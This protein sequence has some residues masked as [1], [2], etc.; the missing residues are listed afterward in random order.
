[1]S[2]A[3]RRKTFASRTWSLCV[4]LCEQVSPQ[5][6]GG[7]LWDSRWPKGQLSPALLCSRSPAVAVTHP[8]LGC[9]CSLPALEVETWVGTLLHSFVGTRG[10]ASVYLLY[11]VLLCWLSIFKIKKNNKRKYLSQLIITAPS[12]SFADRR[13]VWTRSCS[14]QTPGA[15]HGR[16]SQN[17]RV[18]PGPTRVLPIFI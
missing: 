16:Y 13:R 12:V 4:S 9:L 3:T 5:S 8:A 18:V 17:L 7:W 15:S 11:T 10:S 2:T 14:A 6:S 1:M